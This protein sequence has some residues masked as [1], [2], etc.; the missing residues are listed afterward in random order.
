MK[1]AIGADH[2]GYHLKE[3]IK[4]SLKERDIDVVDV[5]CSDTQAVDYPEYACN[6]A[7]QIAEGRAD[8]GILI[9]T[10]G[11]GMS[12]TA[13]RF[14]RVRAALCATP[15]M[16]VKA[17][18]HNDANILAMGGS[19]VS[20]ETAVQILDAWLKT[21][22]TGNDRHERRLQKIKQC[23]LNQAD[24]IAIYD[25]DPEIY[26][27]LRSEQRRESES[28]NLIA[29]ENY[30]S[31]AIRE[32][33]G[34]VLTDKYAEGYPGKRWYNG[35]EHVD[36]AE[37][38]AVD[39]AREL[40]GA[41]HANV[42]PHCGSTANMVVYFSQLKPGDTILAMSLDHG[43]H[44]THGHP[45][46]FSGRL[47]NIIPYGVQRDSERI[48]YD[49]VARLAEQHKPR[50]IVAGASAY[51]RIINFPSLREIADGVHA[52]LM[53]DMAHIAGLV[54]G[55]CHPNPV[56]ESDF[57][58]STT[59]KT[60]RGPRGGL[61]LCRQKY[62]AEINRHLFPGLQGG[63]LM[64]VV[65]AKA[66]CFHE[67]RQQ[68]FQDYAQQIVRNAQTLAFALSN[69]KVRIVSGGTDNHL[70]LAD[71]S[72][73]RVT[74][75]KAAEALDQAGITVNKN[76]IPFDTRSPMVTSGIRL[77]TA[78]LTT[79]GMKEPQMEQI[80]EW[81]AEILRHPDREKTI[82]G[83]AEKVRALA[84]EFPLPS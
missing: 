37:Q 36:V 31:R 81:I 1:I 30:A 20:P 35:C 10:T 26:T 33:Q 48:D 82:R 70:M 71:L 77:G 9:C 66:V 17:R 74:G 32:A 38:L 76:M 73:L 4:N 11:I 7:G 51:P 59:H 42:Q 75:K 84:A 34:S 64:H 63:P 46:N 40:F 83:V 5:G 14:A 58:T 78:A 2:G 56:N 53:V 19:V 12:I 69:Q 39:R 24:P 15:E 43:G 6:V 44:L 57:V 22:F 49:E 29:S 27:V 47:F 72:P 16:A 68:T 25:S 18:S 60:L 79:R 52:L 13:N 50:L 54:A 65:A 62:A 28:L 3:H 67:A 80:G 8:Q 55:G 45:A 41:D 61:V 21:D 23:T